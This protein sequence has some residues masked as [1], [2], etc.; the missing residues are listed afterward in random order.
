MKRAGMLFFFMTGGLNGRHWYWESIVMMRKA[1]MVLTTVL[2]P[3]LKIRSYAAMW[4]VGF[5][6]CLNTKVLP[7]E[8]GRLSRIEVFSLITIFTTLNLGLMFDYVT[9]ESNYAA[10]WTLAV[11]IL[12]MNVLVVAGFVL[13]ILHGVWRRL[14][15]FLYKHPSSR[16]FLLWVSDTFNSKIRSLK[17]SRRN[18]L[19][20]GI[21]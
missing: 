21:Q 12:L 10:Y 2:I 3:D 4:V 17:V 16:S 8:N 15:A 18:H 13:L 19:Q 7:Y 6:Y 20:G 1:L 5:V 14:H 11:A 9:E